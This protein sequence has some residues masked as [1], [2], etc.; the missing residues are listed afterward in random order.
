MKDI[1][2]Q[3]EKELKQIFEQE[4]VVLAY[5]FGSQA[6]GTTHYFSD[7]DIGVLFGK[8]VRPEAYFE[9]GL[10][11][12]GTLSSLL[13]NNHI[14]IVILNT[15]KPFLKYQVAFGGK[16][17]FAFDKTIQTFFE[18]RVMKEHENTKHI[19]EFSLQAMKKRIKTNSFGKLPHTHVS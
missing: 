16:Q 17:I 9:K 2:L 14:D 15:A 12:S 3:Y 18:N 1:F 5:L 10:I 8:T 6:R 19:L 7:V 13:K 4:G 11:L